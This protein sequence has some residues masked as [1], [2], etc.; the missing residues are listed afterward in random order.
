MKRLHLPFLVAAAVV[1]SVVGVTGV[2]ADPLPKV[3][4][5]HGTASATNPFVL[6]TVSGN[7][8]DAQLAQTDSRQQSFVY[9]PSFPTCLDQFLGGPL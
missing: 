3:Q 9:D 5:C 7:A 8:A 6:I 2:R 4:I 1:A